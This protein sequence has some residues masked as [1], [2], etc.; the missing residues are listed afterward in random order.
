MITIKKYTIIASLLLMMTSCSLEETIYD[1]ALSETFIKNDADVAFQLNGVYSFFTTFGGYKSNLT[2]PLLYGGDNIA[3]T[4]STQR[5]FTERTLPASNV[6]HATPWTTYY[7]TINN[8]NALLELL[9]TSQVVSQAVKNKAIGELYFLRAFSYFNLVRFYGGVPI[10]TQP[11]KGDSEFYSPRNSVE[12][13][14]ALIFEDFK[15]AA[16][17]CVLYS[18]QPSTESGR[19]TKG[20]AQALL[21]SAYLTYGNYHDLGGKPDQARIAYQSASIYA[22]SVTASNEYALIENYAN[23]WD[24]AQEKSAYKEVI[25]GIQ[26]TRDALAA[27]ASSR[28]SELPYYLQP[29]TR[30]A[31]CGNVTDGVGAGTLRIQ[32]W[33]YDLYST[34]EYTND[35]RTEV[36]FLTSW[37]NTLTNRAYITYPKVRQAAETVESYPYVDKYKD[38]NGYQARNNENDL[39]IIRLSEVYLIK[40]EAENELN[41]PT[42]LA[43]E[44]FNRLRERARKANGTVRKTPENLATGLTK[45]QFRLKIYDERGLEFVGEG[46]RWFDSIRMRYVD[47]KRTMVQYRYE[48]FYPKLALKTAPSYNATTKVWAGGRVQPLNLVAFSPKFLLWAI[49]SA[50]IDANPKMTQNLGW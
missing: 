44:N 31:I 33:F 39:F 3:T 23:L 12:E 25:F 29:T 46:L 47:N 48:D 20:A 40:A 24:V 15:K 35:Y 32:P 14:Y 42:A 28:G 5:A 19:A 7:N 1:N 10:R 2:Y 38:P 11:T 4:G 8:A 27:S 17:R 37:T 26:H 21:A 30:N 45:E 16:Q 50:E 18:K 41:G 49:P 43:Y 6:Y 34:G 22:D 13:V 9:E 36:S